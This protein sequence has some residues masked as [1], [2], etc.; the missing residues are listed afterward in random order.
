MP[1]TEGR[2]L[3]HAFR[4]HAERDPIVLFSC[5]LGAFGT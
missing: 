1:L 2:T 5:I 3:L 4:I